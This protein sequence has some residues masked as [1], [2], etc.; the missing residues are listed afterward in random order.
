MTTAEELRENFFQKKGKMWWESGGKMT[1]GV[2]TRT[3]TRKKP[4]SEHATQTAILQYL[5]LK[6][7]F[8]WRNNTGAIKTQEGRFLRFGAVGSPDIFAVQNGKVYGI[9]VK[10]D[11]GKLSDMQK[12]WGDRFSQSGGV[13]IVARSIDDIAPIL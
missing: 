8:S 4:S 3:R 9:E 12:D 13:Y 7:I 1:G 5:A 10:A 6:K 2:S 11:T